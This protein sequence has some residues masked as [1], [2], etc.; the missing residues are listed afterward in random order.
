MVYLG[1]P[2]R[3]VS[4]PRLHDP[5]PGYR[6]PRR[7]LPLKERRQRARRDWVLMRVSSVVLV[8]MAGAFVVIM[9]MII[10]TNI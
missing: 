1:G 4:R 2:W 8:L 7:R 6:P 5:P 10:A 9:L 3:G